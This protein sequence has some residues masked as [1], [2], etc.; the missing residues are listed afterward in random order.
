MS[1]KEHQP[2]RPTSSGPEDF[3]ERSASAAQSNGGAD[4]AESEATMSDEEAQ[5]LRQALE[6][7]QAKAQEHWDRLVRTTAELDNVRKRADREVEAARKYALEKFAT[8]LLA[9]R[10]SLEMGLA[11][12][13]EANEANEAN[14]SHVQGMDLTL[15]MLTG[16]MDKFNIQPV[17][18]KGKPFNPEFHEAV[19]MQAS[20]EQ[21]PNTVLS[22]MQKGYMLNDRL[23]RPAMVVVAKAPEDRANDGATS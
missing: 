7:A 21:A 23:L 17:D 4:P 19:S 11:S 9:V 6:E 2:S 18:P 3:S 12:A 5:A 22:V 10:D 14:D 20:A 1:E 8:E 13:R 16:V 15:K